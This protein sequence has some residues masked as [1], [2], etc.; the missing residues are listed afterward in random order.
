M[1]K[2]GGVSWG[3]L[4]AGIAMGVGSVL[5][6]RAVLAW[7]RYS[8]RDDGGAFNVPFRF[9]QV[10]RIFVPLSGTEPIVKA[11]IAPDASRTPDQFPPG[12][13]RARLAARTSR[14]FP[15]IPVALGDSEARAWRIRDAADGPS[16]NANRS[17]T[18][19]PP[20]AARM[21]RVA[22]IRDRAG[23][24]QA[25]TR[26]RGRGGEEARE[27]PGHLSG[28]P[29]P[30]TRAARPA[31]L[32][33]KAS[34][35][36]LKGRESRSPAG[37]IRIKAAAFCPG[38]HSSA[39]GR[40]M[41]RSHSLMARHLSR[42]RVGRFVFRGR[43]GSGTRPRR[44]A[45][46]FRR[47]RPMARRSG[48]PLSARAA[49][50]RLLGDNRVAAP[51]AKAPLEK[52][53]PWSSRAGRRLLADHPEFLPGRS[54]PEILR[55]LKPPQGMSAC[56]M[57]RPHWHE[58][59]SAFFYHAFG[60]WGTTRGGAW[61]WLDRAREG[62]R[63]WGEPGQGASLWRQGRWWL[64][65]HGAWFWVKDGVPLGLAAYERLLSAGLL[66]GQGARL[67]YGAD[68]ARAAARGPGKGAVIFDCLTGEILFSERPDRDVG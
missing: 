8:S 13:A 2:W 48:R 55:G 30:Q 44:R 68:G 18:P 62:W 36:A 58:E 29:P 57:S 43:K 65:A 64:P 24:R 50:I 45:P 9:W 41:K 38:L 49:L 34:R 1:Q 27:Q 31:K 51:V 37:K 7:V 16:D 42:P 21:K 4:T 35:Q 33:P 63:A 22:R 10:H 26:L 66:P 14:M 40:G 17:G 28:R 15:G 67:V 23:S 61:L 11:A 39:R 59:E 46:V 19:R 52:H 60:V 5:I 53:N 56:G 32:A 6:P 25:A 12:P 20:S 3:T 54:F 47:Q